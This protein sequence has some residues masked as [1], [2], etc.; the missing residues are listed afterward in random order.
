MSG[1]YRR[2]LLVIALVACGSKDPEYTGIGPYRFSHTTRK[3][4]HDGVC[5]PQELHTL[6]AVGVLSLSLDYSVSRRTDEFGNVF[7][8]RA[9]LNQGTGDAFDAGKK[10]YDVF[11]VH[12]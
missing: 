7:R 5:Q 11:F 1:M 2:G 8:Y 4:V 10:A 3:D 6:P 9:K 12:K